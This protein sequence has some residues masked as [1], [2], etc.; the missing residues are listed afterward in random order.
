MVNKQEERDKVLKPC[1]KLCQG[2]KYSGA[3]LQYR[4]LDVFDKTHIEGSPDIEIFLPKDGLVWIL[5][6]ECKKPIGG[7]FSKAQIEYKEKYS[8]FKNVVYA[9]VTDVKQL[10]EL[11]CSMSGYMDDK[12]QEMNEWKIN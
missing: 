9:G 11:V 6:C 12:I 5:M 7:V 1:L 10:N 8:K 3:I 2:L 4:R